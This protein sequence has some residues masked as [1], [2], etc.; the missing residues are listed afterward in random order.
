MDLKNGTKFPQAPC[1]QSVS[2]GS[3]QATCPCEPNLSG[4]PPVFLLRA[5]FLDRCFCGTYQEEKHEPFP[6]QLKSSMARSAPWCRTSHPKGIR[7][8]KSNECRLLLCVCFVYA[9]CQSSGQISLAS[10]MI[11]FGETQISV[12][13]CWWPK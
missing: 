6:L 9:S 12:A 10:T 2:N 3:R 5:T 11:W 13:S 4:C 1:K 8:V 7:S